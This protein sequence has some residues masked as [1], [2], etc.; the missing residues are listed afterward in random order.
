MDMREITTKLLPKLYILILVVVILGTLGCKSKQNTETPTIS[1]TSTVSA[2]AGQAA[3]DIMLTPGGPAYRGNVHE[4]GVVNPWPEVQTVETPLNATGEDIR[5]NYRAFIE[6]KAGETRNNILWL[7]GTSISAKMGK[8]VAFTP[9]NLP[10]GIEANSE[11]TTTS[12]MTKAVM[13]INISAQVSTGE[14]TFN[15]R[16]E[17]DGKDYGQVP[18]TIKVIN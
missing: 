3:D 9:E 1:M 4:Q 12:P 5:L 7:Y 13:E 10:S 16:V 15:I 6:T 8:A 11:Q 14:Y 18:C 17:I 2:I